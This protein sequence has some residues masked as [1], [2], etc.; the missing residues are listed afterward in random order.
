MLPSQIIIVASNQLIITIFSLRKWYF[1]LMSI[2]SYYNQ[3]LVPKFIHT[4]FDTY[5]FFL[6]KNI[7]W[8]VI[9]HFSTDK[10]IIWPFFISRYCFFIFI[11][12]FAKE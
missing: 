11:I 8:Q 12:F 4:V 1:L 6:I 10:N 3:K 2:K 7:I 9:R 5:D